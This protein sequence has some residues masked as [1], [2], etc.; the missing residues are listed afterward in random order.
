MQTLVA[1]D[2]GMERGKC[3]STVE[4]KKIGV[5]VQQSRKRMNIKEYKIQKRKEKELEKALEN[6]KKKNVIQ[7]K[8][9]YNFREMQR[10]ITAL[11]QLSSEDRK[12]LHQLN[13]MCK[14]NKITPSELKERIKKLVNSDNIQKKELSKKDKLIETLNE[15]IKGYDSQ[16]SHIEN[17]E[18]QIDNL[19]LEI[20][21]KILQ[22]E[23]L[24]KENEILKNENESL[25]KE[26]EDLAN[27]NEALKNEN[28]SLKNENIS[29]KRVVEKVLNYANYKIKELINFGKPQVKKSVS[30]EDFIEKDTHQSNSSGLESLNKNLEK[31]VST[32]NKKEVLDYSNNLLH[33]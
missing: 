18:K 13:T 14:D 8:E 15:K 25:K 20:E 22:I 33:R 24:E 6:E 27:E 9:L 3:S 28:E 29:Y 16:I 4:A 2:L 17:L 11:N 19:L 5:Q 32:E 10:E 26:N 31:F 7:E 1:N 23:R 21:T 30:I 12:S